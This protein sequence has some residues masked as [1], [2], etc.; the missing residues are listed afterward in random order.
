[1]EF[2]ISMVGADRIML[3]SDYCYDMGYTQPVQ[4][5]DQLALSP[6]DRRM[7]LGGTAARLLKLAA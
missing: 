2:V 6:D 5:V 3:G 7:I 1:M 4:F